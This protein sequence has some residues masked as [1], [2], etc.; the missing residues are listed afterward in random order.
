MRVFQWCPEL[1]EIF[2]LPT[3]DVPV[4]KQQLELKITITRKLSAVEKLFFELFEQIW[5]FY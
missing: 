5:N 1:E 4:N 3:V 2:L